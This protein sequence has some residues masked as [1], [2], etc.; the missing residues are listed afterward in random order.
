MDK[1]DPPIKNTPVS[2]L[3]KIGKEKPQAPAGEYIASCVHA[4]SAWTYL[5]NRKIALYFEVSEG[6][7]D[8]K[9][10]RRFYNLKKLHNGDYEIAPKSKL[11]KDVRKLFPEHCGQEAINPVEL[12]KDKFFIIVVE[13]VLSK[14]GSINSIVT[15]IKLYD[16]GF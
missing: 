3:I 12:F 7:H 9:T 13:R 16:P 10:A 2:N 15:D 4:E 5:G 14:D 11:S 1:I 6:D 8:G